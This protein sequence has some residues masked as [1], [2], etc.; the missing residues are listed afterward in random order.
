M[1]LPISAPGIIAGTLLTFIPAAGDYI[2]VL[3]LGSPT[4]DGR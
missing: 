2:N 3:F 1:T 4:I